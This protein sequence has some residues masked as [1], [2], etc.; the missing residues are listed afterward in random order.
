MLFHICLSVLQVLN[1]VTTMMGVGVM[2][3]YVSH[4]DP[5]L[6]ALYVSFRQVFVR[7]AFFEMSAAKQC[8]ATLSLAFHFVIVGTQHTWPNTIAQD[9]SFLSR[10][11][12]N[13]Y[14]FTHILLRGAYSHK[15]I[16]LHTRP[17]VCASFGSILNSTPAPI[18]AVCYTTASS[19]R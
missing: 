9:D 13:S 10:H 16:F 18:T 3:E 15:H 11:A 17:T 2:E 1:I 8:F 5:T 6:Q 4:L 12:E 19:A 7:F 14:A